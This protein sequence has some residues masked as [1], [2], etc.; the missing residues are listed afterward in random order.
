MQTPQQGTSI[1]TSDAASVAA[2]GTWCFALSRTIF[3][4]SRLKLFGIEKAHL[5]TTCKTRYILS[6]Y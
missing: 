4:Y 6:S 5:P 3:V 2:R 1:S